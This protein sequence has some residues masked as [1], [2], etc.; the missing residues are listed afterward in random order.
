MNLK[1]STINLIC[2]VCTLLVVFGCTFAAANVLH[3]KGSP[4]YVTIPES[5]PNNQYELRVYQTH[6]QLYDGKRLVKTIKVGD[7]PKLDA[8]IEKDNL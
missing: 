1:Q 7:N 4:W 6:Y 2:A 5:K 3:P 8:I